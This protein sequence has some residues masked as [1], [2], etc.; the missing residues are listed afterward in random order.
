MCTLAA[1]LSAEEFGESPEDT[2]GDAA[3]LSG[4]AVSE[5][6]QLAWELRHL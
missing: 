4:W 2:F 6:A 1:S 3:V 5:P